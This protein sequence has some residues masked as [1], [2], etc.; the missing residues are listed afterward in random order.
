MVELAQT[1]AHSTIKSYLS[2]VR[3]LHVIHG[4]GNPLKDTLRL[5]L[6]LRGVQRAKPKGTRT[7]LPV[8]PRI[9]RFIKS[10]LDFSPGFDSTML[11]AACCTAFFGFMRCAEFTTSSTSSYSSRGDL[12][13]EGVAVDSHLE[14][15]VIAIRIKRSKTDQFSTGVTIYLGRTNN[16]LCPVVALLNY[17][18]IRHTQGGPL[19]V[20]QDGRF[21]SK[22]LL[23]Q[24][25]RQ[26][27]SAQGMDS[28]SYSGH[29]FRIGAATT[30]AACGIEDSLIKVLGT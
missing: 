27:L 28:S 12:L 13:A 25:V 18:A 14:P 3:H 22:D 16:E 11:W 30:A 7:R 26:A 1:R 17:L 19:F 20:L 29:S 21:L 6:I 24:R 2:A 10:S 4:L 8:T 15:S 23:V 9:L 5:D